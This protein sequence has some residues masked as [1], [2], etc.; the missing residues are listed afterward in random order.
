MKDDGDLVTRRN[1]IDKV[2]SGVERVLL[3]RNSN[4]DAVKST[5]REA[6][7]MAIKEN[8]DYLVEVFNRMEIMQ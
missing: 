7:K 5:L 6:K 3:V 2:F 4:D 8:S 1:W